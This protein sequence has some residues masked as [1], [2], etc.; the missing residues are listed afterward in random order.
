MQG[1]Q[2]SQLWPAV[3]GSGLDIVFAHQQFKWGSDAKGKA[4]VSVVIVGMAMD[5]GGEKRRLF[6]HGDGAA[7]LEEN[8]RHISPYLIGSARPLPLVGNAS[9]AL[10]GL[11]PMEMGSKAIDGGHYI[12]D[13][14]QREDLLGNDPQ[15]EEFVRP[16]VGGPRVPQRR[17]QVDTCAA[18][19]RA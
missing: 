9:S 16:F 13:D 15:A 4:S 12:L 14:K 8:P 5:A 17:E 3:T 19:R 18:Q 6:Y 11:P 1:E 7:S 10:N 2:V